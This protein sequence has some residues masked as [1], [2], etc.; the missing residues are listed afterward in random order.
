MAGCTV[1]SGSAFRVFKY[2]LLSKIIKLRFVFRWQILMTV[3]GNHLSEYIIH[4][5][6]YNFIKG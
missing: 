3:I 2:F 5:R 4:H 6:F 1:K